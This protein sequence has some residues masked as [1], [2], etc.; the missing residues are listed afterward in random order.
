MFACLR[1]DVL[2]DNVTSGL[3]G[4]CPSH[5]KASGSLHRLVSALE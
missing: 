4:S 1:A 3:G 2:V 5:Q